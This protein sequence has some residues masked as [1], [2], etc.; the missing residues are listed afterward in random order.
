V[1]NQTLE[2]YIRVYGTYRQDDWASK[3][4]LAEYTYNNSVHSTLRVTPFFA[5]YGFNPDIRINVEDDIQEGEAVAAHDRTRQI[6]NERKA[7]DEL[8]ARAVEAQKK[9]YNKKRRP[10]EFKVGDQ[11]MLSTKNL[12]LARPNKKLSDLFLGP[13]EVIY[14]TSN[15]LACKLRLPSSFKIYPV[16]HVSLLEP[17]H[18]RANVTIEPPEP[19][20]IEGQEYWEVERILSHRRRR[21][22]DQYLVRWKGFTPADDTWEPVKHLETVQELVQEY[23]RA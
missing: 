16:F 4:A 13:F 12:K 1:Q 6:A 20:I 7:L 10:I 11:V 22:K 3:L 17:Y 21:G 14:V 5:L 23:H 19:E 15:G 8:W 2:H 9:F 18:Q